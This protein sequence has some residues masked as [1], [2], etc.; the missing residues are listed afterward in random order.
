MIE[1]VKEE[2]LVSIMESLGRLWQE[3]KI[4]FVISII[5][6]KEIVDS[7]LGWD[8][9]GWY[10]LTNKERKELPQDRQPNDYKGFT[11]VIDVCDCDSALETMYKLEGNGHNS[12]GLQR[13]LEIPTDDLNKT[14][15]EV[16]YHTKSNSIVN[17]DSTNKKIKELYNCYRQLLYHTKSNSIVNKNSTNKK[18]CISYRQL[19]SIIGSICGLGHEKNQ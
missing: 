18:L 9:F 13:L 15:I 11:V 3:D 16:L 4:P 2:I 17:K 6:G 14:T 12:Q 19:I 8:F 5:N 1:S 7:P 10:H